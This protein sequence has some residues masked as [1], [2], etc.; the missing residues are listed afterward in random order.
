[1]KKKIIALLLSAMT[2]LS[3][4]SYA[5][6]SFINLFKDF[7]VSDIR[8]DF[9]FGVKGKEYH[10]TDITA[11]A[12]K[13]FWEPY[14]EVT[15]KPF[16]DSE[17]SIRGGYSYRNYNDKVSSGVKQESNVISRELYVGNDWIFGNFRFRPEYGVRETSYGGYRYS[18]IVKNTELRLYPKMDYKFNK[19]WMI[20]TRGF[21]GKYYLDRTGTTASN[22]GDKW[23][24]EG[25]VRY[26]FNRKHG[27]SLAYSNSFNEENRF[28]YETK[29]DEIR[30]R[31]HWNPTRKLQLQPHVYFGF[32]GERNRPGRNPNSN[33]GDGKY[34]KDRVG[35]N[36]HYY[37]NNSFTLLFQI[38]Y[39]WYTDRTR[40]YSNN[41]G[42]SRV[43][44]R[45]KDNL[46]YNMGFKYSI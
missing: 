38:H 26:T 34:D 9:E 20:Y 22:T 3:V 18:G 46:F 31:Y 24:L 16:Q 40:F 27:V 29:L 21:Y 4:P 7:K 14:T 2:L 41:N 45:N 1:M 42:S 33:G 43:A 25:G 12:S 13:N 32:N 23:R 35:I 19:N 30:L 6:D 5:A 39:E 15:V 17:F 36:G 11:G 28:A 10:D 37:I 44:A 8:A